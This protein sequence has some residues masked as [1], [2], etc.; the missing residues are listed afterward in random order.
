M[1]YI[2]ACRKWRELASSPVSRAMVS[3]A[4]MARSASIVWP[5]RLRSWTNWTYGWNGPNGDAGTGSRLP[6]PSPPILAA[7]ATPDENPSPRWARRRLV[8]LHHAKQVAVG[9]GEVGQP[10]HP[11]H[12][13]PRQPDLATE[14]QR[15]LGGRVQVVDVDGHHEGVDRR[16]GGRLVALAGHHA[17]VDPGPAVVTGGDH[18]VGHLAPLLECPAEHLL[19]E[20]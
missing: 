20:L 4:S 18:P 8:G 3:N 13:H 7:S 6:V 10:T 14:L 12:R 19:V 11:G 5:R 15:G 9:V 16:A 17:A 1:Q 2:R